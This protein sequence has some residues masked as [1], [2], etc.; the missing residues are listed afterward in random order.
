[1]DGDLRRAAVA[2]LV[3]LGRGPDFRDGADA[4]QALAAFAELPEAREPLL[5][6]LTD[7]G[8]TYVTL[9]TAKALLRRNDEAGVSL[10][11]SALAVANDNHGDH[12]HAAIIEVLGIF[13]QDLDDAV[14]C[15]EEL[16]RGGGDDIAARGAREMRSILLGIDP[17]LRA[18]QPE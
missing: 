10:V 12:L 1:M 18:Q 11:A 8:D 13:S 17:V 4:G 9:V 15:C 3:K 14:R 6:F 2:A 5:E 7:A 16:E